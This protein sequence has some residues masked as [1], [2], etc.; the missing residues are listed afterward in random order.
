MLFPRKEKKN[1]IEYM[2]VFDDASGEFDPD[3]VAN[4]IMKKWGKKVMSSGV[5]SKK[6]K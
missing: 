2:K 4:I 1:F 3:K 6:T 5:G